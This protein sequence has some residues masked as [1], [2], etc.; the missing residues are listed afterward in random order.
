MKLLIHDLNEEDFRKLFPT[1]EKDIVVV[2][3]D[4]PIRNCIGCFGCWIKTPAVC[5]IRDKYGDMGEM[6]SKCD[7]IHIISQCLYGGFSHFIK[8]VLDRSI[9]YV[10]PYFI[11]RN[12][13]MHHRPRYNKRVGLKVWFYGEDITDTEETTAKKLIKANAINL[14]ILD[15]TVSFFKSVKDMEVKSL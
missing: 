9:S 10:H 13:E 1:L 4:A 11:I 8:N 7:E 3:N 14:N 12:G 2:S 15:N 6:L 5:V